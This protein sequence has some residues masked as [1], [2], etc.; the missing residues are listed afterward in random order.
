MPSF[1]PG[2]LFW[3][4]LLLNL[5]LAPEIMGIVA[6]IPAFIIAASPESLDLRRRWLPFAFA[7]LGAV[8]LVLSNI[9]CLAND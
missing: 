8:V 4:M 9:E 2:I 3:Q 5:L 1:D 7:G 6:G